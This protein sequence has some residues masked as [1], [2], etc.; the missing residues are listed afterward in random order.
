MGWWCSDCGREHDTTAC[1]NPVFC[2]SSLP[3]ETF[4]WSG[5]GGT[6]NSGPKFFTEDVWDTD[7]PER[8]W[9]IRLECIKQLGYAIMYMNF[10]HPHRRIDKPFEDSTGWHNQRVAVQTLCSRL[11]MNQERPDLQWWKDF[12][13]EI[14][15]EIEN[16]C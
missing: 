6:G 15:D 8:W 11:A 10:L 1:P 2:V 13:K 7:V 16:M 4:E 9:C 5:A 12:L 14:N 3:G